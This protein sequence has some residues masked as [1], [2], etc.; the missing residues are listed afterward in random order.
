MA[1]SVRVARGAV[2]FGKQRGP[3]LVDR[4]GAVLPARPRA[5]NCAPLYS[6]SF[7]Q[8]SNTR[9][10]CS[11]HGKL[12]GDAYTSDAASARKCQ[13]DRT[14]TTAVATP[15]VHTQAANA[16][17]GS[18]A[19][20]Y[21]FKGC[22]LQ[23]AIVNINVVQVSRGSSCPA[24]IRSTCTNPDTCPFLCKCL[25]RRAHRRMEVRCRIVL[26][27]LHHVVSAGDHLTRV[28]A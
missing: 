24:M 14:H 8:G 28:E 19:I 9:F 27:T 5:P 26:Q 16:I 17:I 21:S 25:Q 18:P 2:G 23:H 22:N 12:S 7:I 4:N 3:P 13:A 11:C 1:E 20:A 6:S 10:W 15:A